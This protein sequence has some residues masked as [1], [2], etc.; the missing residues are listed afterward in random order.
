MGIG[1]F[2]IFSF[3]LVGEGD[4]AELDSGDGVSALEILGEGVAAKLRGGRG[5]MQGLGQVR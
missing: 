2:V 1:N 3:P 4:R 5:R